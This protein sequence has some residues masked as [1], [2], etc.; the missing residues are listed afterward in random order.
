MIVFRPFA[1]L[2]V[3]VLSSVM[4][5]A[6]AGDGG[7]ADVRDESL[8]ISATSVLNFSRFN[9]AGPAGAKGRIVVGTN[10]RMR[11]ADSNEALTLHCA[12]LA[13]SPAT[14]GFLKGKDA[15][16]YAA[17]LR[18][19]GFNLVRFHYVEATLMT[20]RDADFDFDP[21]QLDAW[22]YFLSALKKQGVY[23]VMDAMTSENGALG[24][25]YPHRWVAKH[26][27]K[28]RIYFDEAAREHWRQLVEKLLARKNPYT[29]MT[30]LQDPALLGVITVNEGGINHLAAQ[31]EAWPPLLKDAFNVW[32]KEH[33]GGDDALRRAWRTLAD[34]ER[35]DKRSV[36]LPSKLRDRTP[37]MRDVQRFIT[38]L[39]TEAAQWM[40]AHLRGLGYEG[41]VTGLDSWPSRQADLSRRT[42]E[43][44]DMHGYH[45]EN[46]GFGPGVR[47]RQTSALDNDG[48]YL[49][50]LAAAR[51]RGKPYSVTEY[52]QPFWN[53]Y[54]YEA[55]LMGPAMA[56]LQQWDFVCMHAEGAIDLSLKQTVSRKA[57]IHPYGLGVDPVTIAGETLAA[58]M[59]RRGDIAPAKRKALI[60]F[61]GAEFAGEPVD[62]IEDE[63]STMSWLTRVELDVS[64]KAADGTGYDAI[65]GVGAQPQ[66]PLGRVLGKLPNVQAGR[67]DR[68][69]DELRRVGVLSPGNKSSAAAGVF[70]S[71]TGEILLDR[72][73]GL[74]R[75]ITPRTQ[76]VSRNRPGGQVQVGSMQVQS[77]SAP[78]LLAA[79]SLD[80][81]PL[82]SSQ[83][84]LL[85]LATD[86]QNTGM[87]FTDASRNTLK[88]LGTMP[89]QVK[90]ANAN[91]TL[92]TNVA[93]AFKLKA[94]TLNGVEREE[95]PIDQDGEILTIKIANVVGGR[96]TSFF[97]LSTD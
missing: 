51:Q 63:L 24:A 55:S 89:P 82:L 53:Q 65:F 12:S 48:R 31:R 88:R 50:W 97:L 83:K 57:A 56:S 29:G 78:A 76:A 25:V 85:I 90:I 62:I 9:D 7:W 54:R 92:R 40:T 44:I 13:L 10:G 33:Y 41:L 49:R 71:E 39:E 14:G 34:S 19:H 81:L 22:F 58:V 18:A 94:L 32:L 91:L 46:F 69:I 87:T 84:I 86:A 64:Q 95:I 1:A 66:T 59:L 28:R 15:D 93:H 68:M 52:G 80:D 61:S 70:E 96:A 4:Q 3:A 38:G 75:V 30:T 36:E 6:H 47:M 74:F 20:K 23:W 73:Q 5:V 21:A 42:F 35:T 45:D 79:T 37:R 67:A 11:Y 27:L 72:G 2:L 16:L 77:V 60:N 43:W 8:V 26:D 17:Q